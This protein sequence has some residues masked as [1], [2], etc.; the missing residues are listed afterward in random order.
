MK[1][2]TSQTPNA[3]RDVPF[4]ILCALEISLYLNLREHNPS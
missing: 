1:N 2:G 3:E 4:F